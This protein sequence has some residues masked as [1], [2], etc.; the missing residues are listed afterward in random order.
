VPTDRHQTTLNVDDS[1]YLLGFRLF[2]ICILVFTAAVRTKLSTSF[3]LKA[4]LVN[5]EIR[6]VKVSV[7]F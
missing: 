1:A 5:V 7:Y 6:C 4:L 2:S 3:V